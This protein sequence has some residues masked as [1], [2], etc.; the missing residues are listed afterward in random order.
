MFFR[1]T[2]PA[3]LWAVLILALTLSPA[4]DLPEATW[5]TIYNVDKVIH[6]VLFGV[7]YFLLMR[8]L[9][10]QHTHEFYSRVVL[11]IVISVILY[12]AVIEILQSVLPIGRSGGLADWLAD[13]AGT[14]IAYIFYR[15]MHRHKS[16]SA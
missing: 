11:W 5:I 10:K 8:G 6:A 3:F 4:S 1:H 13:C 9:M 7:L 14:G 12:G 2:Y 16:V 15:R